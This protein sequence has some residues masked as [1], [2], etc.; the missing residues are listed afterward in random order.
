MP[1]ARDEVDAGERDGP[2][3]ASYEFEPSPDTI[4]DL[5]LPR[6]VESR[7]FAAL[8]ERGGVGA[9]ARASAR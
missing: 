4:L 5:L 7:V 8:L 9:R 3:A 2:V 1:L 6:Y